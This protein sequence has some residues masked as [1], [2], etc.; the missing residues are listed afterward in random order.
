[1]MAISSAACLVSLEHDDRHLVHAGAL[2]RAPAPLAGDDLVGVGDAGDRAHEDRLQDA[3]LFDRGGEILE[4]GLVEILARLARIGP[5]ELDRHETAGRAAG[6]SPRLRSPA[7]PSSAANPRP[8]LGRASSAIR[9]RSCGRA[10]PFA[11]DHL[12]RRAGYRPG[13]RSSGCRRAAPA[14]R[15]TAPR[16]R[17]RCAG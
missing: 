6:R 10:A 5:Q 2:R 7:S 15:A 16:T 11:P 9:V 14:C 4:L 17:A 3:A 12:A 8:S 13:C 1:M